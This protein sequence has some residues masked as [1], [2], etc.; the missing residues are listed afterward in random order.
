MTS[1]CISS[2]FSRL[3]PGL[4][5]ALTD[6]QSGV[7][8]SASAQAP[9]LPANSARKVGAGLQEAFRE[10]PGT[11]RFSLLQLRNRVGAGAQGGQTGVAMADLMRVTSEASA[12]GRNVQAPVLGVTEETAVKQHLPTRAALLRKGAGNVAPYLALEISAGEPP[13]KSLR[14]TW[15]P[16]P[17]LCKG[18]Q[19]TGSS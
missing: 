3:A 13:Q 16:R 4:P 17:L 5:R 9:I 1:H 18:G 15:G 8:A 10:Q 7:R 2:R 19:G 11:Q 6:K 12:P 14:R